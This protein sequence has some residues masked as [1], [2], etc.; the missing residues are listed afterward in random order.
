VTI[1]NNDVIK[2]VVEMVL[3]DGTIAQNVWHYLAGLENSQS[4]GD[5]TSAIASVMD[6]LY[7]LI[8]DYVGDE[9]IVNPAY[10]NIVSWSTELQKWVVDR[11]LGDETLTWE[12]A[13]ANDVMPNQMAAVITAST[14]RPKVHG[15]KFF[16][17]FVESSANAGDLIAGAVTALTAAAAL[18][19]TPLG[20]GGNNYLYAMVPSTTDGASLPL[21]SAQVNSIMGTMRRR[22]P[23]VGV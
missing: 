5:V 1:E 7:T 19:L 22:K 21:T 15:R 11:D 13:S 10:F 4:D 3:S 14:A 9:I 8:D 2:C 12:G 18:W 20:L 17:F 16:P 6:A 23:G